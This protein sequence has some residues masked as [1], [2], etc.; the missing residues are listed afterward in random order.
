[1]DVKRRA[2]VQQQIQLARAQNRTG[3]SKRQQQI[4]GGRR[5]LLDSFRRCGDDGKWRGKLGVCQGKREISSLHPG[6]CHLIQQ[7]TSLIHFQTSPV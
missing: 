1:M 7:C 4:Y 6:A 2:R 3:R 5:E